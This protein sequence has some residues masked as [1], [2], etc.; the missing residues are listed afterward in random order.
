MVVASMMVVPPLGFVV[1][2]VNG[3][4]GEGDQIELAV[5]TGVDVADD[6]EVSA[7][8]EGLTFGRLVFVQVVRHSVGEARV[9]DGEAGAVASQP[10]TEEMSAIEV[11]GGATDDEV[12]HIS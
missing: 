7:P 12:A 6:A 10:E 5:R 1:D 9:G 2:A 11:R 8:E 3:P 4:A